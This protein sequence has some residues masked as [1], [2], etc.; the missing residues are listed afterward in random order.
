[1]EKFPC[2]PDFWRNNPWILRIKAWKLIELHTT[3]AQF[4]QEWRICKTVFCRINSRSNAKSINETNVSIYS[5]CSNVESRQKR[6]KT[7]GNFFK[8][9]VS[10]LD[11]STDQIRNVFIKTQ[12]TRFETICLFSMWNIQN[13]SWWKKN[14][15]SSYQN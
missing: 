3:Q 4:L 5:P 14:S 11:H 13:D 6:K 8:T 12:A 10:S 1:M 7:K 2:K 9:S 15:I